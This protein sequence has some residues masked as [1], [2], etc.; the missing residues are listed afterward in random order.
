MKRL[1]FIF[2]M[3]S[4]N[5]FSQDINE[6]KSLSKE[7]I[8]VSGDDDKT[9]IKITVPGSPPPNLYYEKSASITSAAVMISDV[10]AINWCYGCT[11][12]AAAMLAGY[13]D[14]NGYNDIYTGTVNGGVFPLTNNEWGYG[15]CPLSASHQGVEGRISYG[16]V[17]DYYYDE[18]D[19]IDPYLE[20]G[21]TAHINDCIADYMKTSQWETYENVDGATTLYFWANGSPYESNHSGD[22]G[23]GLEQFFESKGYNVVNRYNQYINGVA[24]A[25]TGFTFENYINEIDNNRP[26]FIHLEGHSMLGIGYDSNSST[27]YFHNTWDHSV[28]SMT[29]GSYYSSMKHYA[30]TVFELEN[31][32]PTVSVSISN[33]SYTY[34][35]SAKNV[36][37]TTSPA[38]LENSISYY[39][40]SGDRVYSPTNAGTYSVKVTI[41]ESGYTSQGPFL[42]SLVINK[43]TLIVKADNQEV[44]YDET[45]PTY[46]LT[47][48]GFVSGESAINLSRQPY[49]FISVGWPAIPGQY[50]IYISN[51]TD[52]NYKLTYQ[53]GILTVNPI[54]VENVVFSNT[55]LLYNG[56]D[57]H[58]G[59][60]TIPAAV[61]YSIDYFLNETKISNPKD[62]GAY[63]VEVT[64]NQVGYAADS[65]EGIFTISQAP[66]LVSVA[67]TSAIYKHFEPQYRITYSGFVN[68]EDITVLDTKP[69]AKISNNWP[70]LPGIYEIALSEVT[71][72]NY[73]I[74]YQGGYL[75]VLPNHIDSV[76]FSEMN[77]TYDGINHQATINSFPDEVSFEVLYYDENG[78]ITANISDAGE[79]L[80][81]AIVSE[82]GY[83]QDTFTQ[84]LTIDKALLNIVAK[85]TTIYFGANEPEY[86]FSCSGFVLGEDK[87]NIDSLPKVHV[88]GTWPLLP[89]NY[90]IE[91]SEGSDNN[92]NFVF[93]NGQLTVE[94]SDA[95]IFISDTIVTY[96]GD[97]QEATINTIPTNI[98]YEVLYYD[99]TNSI[100]EKPKE[101]GTYFVKVHLTES[102]YNEISKQTSFVIKKAQLKVVASDDSILYA[103]SLPYF[104]FVISGYV[105]S[106]DEKDLDALPV[107]EIEEHS[108][109]LPGSYSIIVSGGQAANYNFEYT[110]GTLTVTALDIQSIN[111]SDTL[112]TYNG[113]E[114]SIT[115][116]T[117]P[118]GIK[119]EIS[120]FNS[121][122]LQIPA[123]ANTGE[124]RYLIEITESGYAK[125]TVTGSLTILKSD[126]T[127]SSDTIWVVYGDSIPNIEYRYSGFIK[128]DTDNVFDKYPQSDSITDWPWAVGNYTLKTT[129]GKASNYNMICEDVLLIVQPAML[130]VTPLDTVIRYGDSI[131]AL[132]F[133]I[134]G[135]KFD[136]TQSVLKALPMVYADSVNLLNPGEHILFAKG[137]KAENYVFNYLAGILNIEPI[138]E[139]KIELTDTVFSY[140]GQILNVIPIL[141][142]ANLSFHIEYSQ[143]PIA[144]GDYI[145]IATITEPGYYSLSDSAIIHINKASLTVTAIDTCILTGDDL[146][147]FTYKISG[148][149]NN[150]TI[151]VIDQLPDFVQYNELPLQVG[152]Y[153]ITLSGGKDNN[154][155]FTYENGV[156]TLIQGFWAKFYASENGYLNSDENDVAQDSVWQKVA[157]NNNS[158][159]IYA[160]PNDGYVFDSWSNG[161]D[162]N[163][164][165]IQNLT[166]DSTIV[167]SFK[168]ATDIKD[169]NKNTVFKVYP[170]P[171]NYADGF[172]IE[173]KF[174]GKQYSSSRI[175]ISDLLGR[176]VFEKYNIEE[177]TRPQGL[178]RGV[179]NVTLFIDN[180]RLS[181]RRLIIK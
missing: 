69:S 134:S 127:V 64:I 177:H 175:V 37:V 100:I 56:N 40:E 146:P 2:L 50:S 36:T 45:E 1:I 155:D 42:G 3:I 133:S 16:H 165:I 25:S 124:Y 75:T 125:D 60:A 159:L 181:I 105:A 77:Y 103:D 72:N 66:L 160:V 162:Q 157:I 130:T 170:N 118:E 138:G 131:L 28:H 143:E 7:T 27:I 161:D 12:T 86:E 145:A 153:P 142:P 18:N 109:Y 90:S 128:G 5:G 59:I 111:I 68:N 169:Y 73:S 92:Y 163:P 9:L 55:E 110:N 168:L 147:E 63:R 144:A 116:S 93:K 107:T 20:A 15:E 67:D 32:S 114:Q 97:E 136:E 132:N 123:P 94:N 98:Q 57:Q 71:D 166:S 139:A 74:S 120:Y 126:L 179:Y 8:A 49:A 13:Y 53:T 70:A 24:G 150:E 44:D 95:V 149:V 84:V 41:T 31:A 30:V 51:V 29:W 171:T 104:D 156:L 158:Q 11:P 22:G 178:P 115:V 113:E 101:A 129:E 174:S 17:D 148:F 119:Y 87:N 47:Y 38:G 19:T 39:N 140:N 14:R 34:D 80:V 43:K 33:N 180:S 62:A 82:P 21:R 173:V 58:I 85:D 23:F 91:L 4:I 35:G 88:N 99:S 106:E 83:T 26:V 167:A 172:N 54:S 89:G 76:N 135:F 96:N 79:Y 137:G 102:G 78:N 81:K 117:V 48:S 141:S 6:P 122:N 108:V 151:E 121:E 65:F 154:Y 52:I 152:Q 176:T 46:S 112:V 10:P 61:N 164:A